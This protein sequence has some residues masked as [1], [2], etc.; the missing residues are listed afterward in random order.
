M[1][2]PFFSTVCQDVDR[3]TAPGSN[4]MR[5]AICCWLYYMS[6]FTEFADTFFFIARKK[7]AHVSMLQVRSINYFF[8]FLSSLLHRKEEICSRLNAVG[9]FEPFIRDYFKAILFVFN[10]L[11]MLQFGWVNKNIIV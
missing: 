2:I 6:K 10:S 4:G 9:S 11:F 7:F 3:S 1:L 8:R 5:M